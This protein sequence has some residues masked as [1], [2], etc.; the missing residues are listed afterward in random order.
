MVEKSKLQFQVLNAEVEKFVTKAIDNQK[1]D[2]H[3]H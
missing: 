2:E 1:R 3:I